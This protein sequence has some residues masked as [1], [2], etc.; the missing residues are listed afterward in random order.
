MDD[1]DFRLPR[2]AEGQ[3]CILPLTFAVGNPSQALPSSSQGLILLKKPRTE[4]YL[5]VGSFVAYNWKVEVLR[6]LEKDFRLV[7]IR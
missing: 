7:E 1:K 5:R 4:Y 2:E 6:D 3:I